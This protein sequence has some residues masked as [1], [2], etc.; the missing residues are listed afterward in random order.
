MIAFYNISK[1]IYFQGETYKIT[2][3]FDWINCLSIAY[4]Y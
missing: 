4:I 2:Y 3:K 1:Y